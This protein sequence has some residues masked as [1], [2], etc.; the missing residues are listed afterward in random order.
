MSV[1]VAKDNIIKP[2][3]PSMG[4]SRKHM[5]TGQIKSQVDEIWDTCWAGG[6]AN[7]ISVI[8]QITYLL[9]IRR[10]D[11]KAYCM[12]NKSERV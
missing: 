7:P 6:I 11:E 12:S 4:E 2:L 3:H 5:I 9:F 1:S 10:L 8:E